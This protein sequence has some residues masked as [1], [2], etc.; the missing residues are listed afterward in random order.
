MKMKKIGFILLAIIITSCDNIVYYNFFIKNNCNYPI[1]IVLVNYEKVETY[2]TIDS[3]KEMKV[4]ESEGLD[5]L[6]NRKIEFVFISIIA[7]HDQD[8]TKVNY[9]HKDLWDFQVI[10]DQH[11]NCYLEIDSVDFN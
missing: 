1:K 8:T 2:K 5:P 11:A 3:N 7:I 10:D 6:S 4:Y 9:V